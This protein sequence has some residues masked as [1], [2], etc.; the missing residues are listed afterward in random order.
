MRTQQKGN[1]NGIKFP[2]HLNNQPLLGDV[3]V[4][5]MERIGRDELDTMIPGTPSTRKQRMLSPLNSNSTT[6]KARGY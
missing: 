2:V 6:W 5:Y 3:I 1:A 4:S